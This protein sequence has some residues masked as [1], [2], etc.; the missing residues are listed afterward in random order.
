MLNYYSSII[1]RLNGGEIISRSSYYLSLVRK[2]VAGFIVFGGEL[3]AVRKGV[4]R[5][6]DEARLPLIIASDLE[7]GLGQQVTGG[8]LFPPAMA[9]AAAVKH[10]AVL[11]SPKAAEVLLRR[12][13]RAFAE[14]ALYAGINTILAP[15]LD[16]NTNPRNPIIS[17]RAFGENAETVSFFGSRMIKTL[18]RNG[19][20]ACGKHFPGHG[21]TEIDS[22]IRLPRIDK[23]IARLKRV[24]L[25]PFGEAIRSGV[26]MLM[27][28]HLK[29][30]AVDPSGIPMSIS[31]EAV[32]RLRK[33]GRAGRLF[34]G[35]SRCGRP[36]GRCKYPASSFLTRE[37]RR[38]AR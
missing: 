15:V 16:I 26:R 37:G 6:Q 32:R 28:G 33:D 24:E 38:P 13:Y 21:D 36:Q 8:T 25:R 20:A 3:N 19:I 31:C 9:V 23:N 5:L 22:H 12:T 14:E 4:Q 17:I 10:V 2:G 7:Q 27:L 18:Q 30:P 34:R 29:V 35:R 11:K 1:P